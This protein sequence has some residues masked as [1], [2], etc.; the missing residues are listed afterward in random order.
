[1]PVTDTIA[2]KPHPGSRLL[3]F[4]GDTLTFTLTLPEQRKGTAYLRTNLGHADIAR[5]D[6]K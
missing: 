3:K 4:R 2:L 1:M 6:T 5:K